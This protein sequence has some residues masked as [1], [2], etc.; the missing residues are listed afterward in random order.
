M[1][2]MFTGLW[3]MPFNKMLDNAWEFTPKQTTKRTFN[4]KHLTEIHSC[5][6]FFF[7]LCMVS[8]FNDKKHVWHDFSEFKNK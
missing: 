8:L 3:K 7:N 4:R 2:Q 5:F 1:T 6:G